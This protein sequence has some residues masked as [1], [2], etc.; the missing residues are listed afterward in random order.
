MILELDGYRDY[1]EVY[2]ASSK[3]QTVQTPLS[4]LPSMADIDIGKYGIDKEQGIELLRRMSDVN[5]RCHMW[6]TYIGATYKEI[7]GSRQ[8]P[9]SIIYHVIIRRL[10]CQ[11]PTMRVADANTL[12]RSSASNWSTTSQNLNSNKFFQNTTEPK[13]TTRND[14]FGSIAQRA[15]DR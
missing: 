1:A 11:C 6:G 5:N 14:G 15:T 10:P 8:I 2:T 4:I 12:H 13:Q 7:N 3:L 9:R